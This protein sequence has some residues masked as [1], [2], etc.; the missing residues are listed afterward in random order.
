MDVSAE[1]VA[2]LPEPAPAEVESLPSQSP[3]PPVITRQKSERAVPVVPK[4]ES[5]PPTLKLVEEALVTKRLVEVAEVPVA[6][7]KVNF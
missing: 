6:L 7:M 1:E 2:I 4:R 5:E 3:A